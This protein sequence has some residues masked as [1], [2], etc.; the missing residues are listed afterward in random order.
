MVKTIF[1]IR[2]VKNGHVLEITE[3]DGEVSELVHEESSSCEYYSW[4]SLLH[5][6]T[7][8]YGPQR[9]SYAKEQI[10]I[11]VRPGRKYES[12]CTYAGIKVYADE[13]C[14]EEFLKRHGGCLHNEV[15]FFKRYGI[16]LKYISVNSGV[17]KGFPDDSRSR[18]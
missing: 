6:L 4:A 7:D 14:D 3:R 12:E 9:D 16:P 8:Y 5:Q 13:D 1:E 17:V 15:H 10:H 2:P 18:G 11:S